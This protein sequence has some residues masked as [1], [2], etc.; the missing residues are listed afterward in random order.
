MGLLDKLGGALKGAA[1]LAEGMTPGLIASALAK[2]NLGDL[3]GLVTQLQAGGLGQQV[4]S[5]LSN[6]PNLP[7][8]ADQLRAALG[9]QQI[10]QLAEHFGLP[11]D[12]T[13]DLLARNL[14]AA[15]DQASPNGT[16][17]NS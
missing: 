14:P 2:S 5:W 6:N 13:L 17:T 9:N 1:G 3:Q 7:V 11:V 16:L 12:D 15:V 8:T 4:Q 10:R